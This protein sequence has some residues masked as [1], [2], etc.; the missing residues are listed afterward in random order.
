MPRRRVTDVIIRLSMN[1]LGLELYKAELN[2][3]QH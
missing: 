2:N 3:S 1:G